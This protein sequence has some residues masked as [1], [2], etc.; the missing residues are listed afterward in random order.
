MTNTKK[1]TIDHRTSFSRK[2]RWGGE[3]TQAERDK[4]VAKYASH[5]NDPYKGLSE[6]AKEEMIYNNYF[7]AL[8]E[9]DDVLN[10][11]LNTLNDN[12]YYTELLKIENRDKLYQ[13]H[14][15]DPVT[16]VQNETN[17]AIITGQA[18]DLKGANDDLKKANDDL[19]EANDDLKEANDDLKA[20]N[21]RLQSGHLVDD[22]TFNFFHYI[23]P[24]LN[25]LF[26]MHRIILRVAEKTD[27]QNLKS[28]KKLKSNVSLRGIDIF[29]ESILKTWQYTLRLP[30]MF[31]P[32][33]SSDP[34]DRAAAKVISGCL[35]R[36]SPNNI[37]FSVTTDNKVTA[38]A[39]QSTHKSTQ[40]IE[41]F[42]NAHK[43]LIPL[44]KKH[45][46]QF[47]QII[48]KRTEFKKLRQ[49]K[50]E[51][52]KQ[53]DGN[54]ISRQ[55]RRRYSL[56]SQPQSQRQSQRRTRRRSHRRT[57][58]TLLPTTW[59][60]KTVSIDP[61]TIISVGLFK[62]KTHNKLRGDVSKLF[63]VA[64]AGANQFKIYCKAMPAQNYLMKFLSMYI[65]GYKKCVQRIQNT[66]NYI[67]LRRGRKKVVKKD[68]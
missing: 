48:D 32:E 15:I 11:S 59:E 7:N 47:K 3:L 10:Y 13:K 41:Q 16:K 28:Y 34:V 33:A 21:D 54:P 49:Q 30:M 22:D 2:R 23:I 62:Y 35:T 14:I 24:G 50:N 66:I 8:D 64:Y 51:E 57:W 60:K 65:T 53:K 31:D 46:T 44:D 43:I 6:D 67:I 1:N 38:T 37:Y 20:A 19:K 36:S 68:Q 45:L 27:A 40:D 5:V 61:N 26:L 18:A 12:L 9:E 39:T 4:L 58:F 63:C 17:E 42:E 29:E 25:I 52:V 55:T 56:R